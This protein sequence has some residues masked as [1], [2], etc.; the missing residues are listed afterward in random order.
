VPTSPGPAPTP[1]PTSPGPPAPTPTPVPASPGPTPTP[2]PAS[3]GQ[4]GEASSAADAGAGTSNVGDP[5]ASCHQ[6][7]PAE[8]AVRVLRSDGTPVAGVDVSAAGKSGTT[9]ADGVFDFGEVPPDS[10]TATGQKDE[11]APPSSGSA[12]APASQTLNAPAGT[13]TQFELVLD[14]LKA[15]IAVH[16]QATDGSPVEGVTV[17]VDGKGWSGVTDASGN[18]DFGEVPPDT[19]TVNGQKDCF[20]PPNAQTQNAPLGASTQ[21]Q[22]V[23]Q[24][25]QFKIQYNVNG[26]WKDVPSPLGPICPGSAAT[27]KA[28]I[29][30]PSG[31]SWPTGSPVWGGDAVGTGEQ[32]T[33]T[34][35]NSGARFVSAEC[36]MK[37][38]LNVN[39]ADPNAPITITWVH[40]Y[41]VDTAT[42]NDTTKERPFTVNF[43]ACAD[44]ANNEWHLRV[45]SIQGGV[46]IAVHM[47]GYMTPQPGVN[48]TTETQGAN[49]ITD[50]LRR[51]PGG[52]Q[53]AGPGVW[54][55]EAATAAHE[56]W[57][58]DE[59]IQ[60]CE[61]YWPAAEA[62]VEKLKVPY[63]TH[64][65][66]KASAVTDLRAGASGADAKLTAFK[67]VS[68]R[69]WFTLGDSFGDRP[70]FAGAATMN[71]YIDAIRA[72]G[73]SQTPPWT[74]PA[75][76]N[77]GP[78]ADHCYQ[79]WL[80]YS[81]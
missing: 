16:V 46:D 65:N 3:Q 7:Q 22:L 61:H 42:A 25:F 67:D 4:L 9:G 72:Y 13:S 24:P 80:P 68:K 6:P 50:M 26:T 56:G 64:E 73:A 75:G 74:L 51:M 79:P 77:S 54:N 20:A 55:T 71:P 33:V 76:S 81:P 57:H 44:V 5:G 48:I 32:S 70:Y 2:V 43:D 52:G 36:G 66:D 53:G 30:S 41:T 60:T 69:Y 62:A 17:S 35:S 47:G 63:D 31:A 21:Y 28:V 11:F 39:V 29:T 14:P 18:F 12:S 45:K 49:A 23:M 19:Y 37:Q 59:W 34:F 15:R 8:I 58:R 27:F 38:T 78:P 40:G 10:Y 1:V